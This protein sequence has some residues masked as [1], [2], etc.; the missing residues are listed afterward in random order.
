MHE[1]ETETAG[2]DE[3]PFLGHMVAEHD[4]QGLLQEMRR[5]MVLRRG[6]AH[7]RI[8][9]KVY[10]LADGKASLLNVSDVRDLVMLRLGRLDTENA[11]S[12]GDRAEIALLS[13]L[14]RVERRRVRDDRASLA[15]RQGLRDL[16]GIGQLILLVIFHLRG[17]RDDRSL[18]LKTVIA[19]ETGNEIGRELLIGG[20]GRAGIIRDLAA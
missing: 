8:D 17:H 19:G 14:G 6:K 20:Q 10:Q 9:R 13:A 1:I 4:L 15:F 11:V 5:G 7:R 12:R 18:I 16:A 3:R 2:R